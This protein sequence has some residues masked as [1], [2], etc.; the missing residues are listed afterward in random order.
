[1]LRQ[2]RQT[3]EQDD[4]WGLAI[5]FPSGDRDS[6]DQIVFGP[7]PGSKTQTATVISEVAL[8]T[9]ERLDSWFTKE[10]EDHISECQVGHC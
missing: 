3:I 6:A 8:R 9:G 10:R 2:R 1:M 5:T 4:R 7:Q